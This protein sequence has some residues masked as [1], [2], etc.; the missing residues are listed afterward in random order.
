VRAAAREA[1]VRQL[2]LC[3]QLEDAIAAADPQRFADCAAAIEEAQLGRSSFD[4]ECFTA[5]VAALHDER[6][7]AAAGTWRLLLVVDLDHEKLSPD[8]R[9]RMLDALVQ[10]YPRFADASAC[11]HV[12][13]L[14][15]NRFAGSEGLQ[16]LASLRAIADD[17][18]RSYIA[19]GL[20]DTVRSADD[21]AVRGSAMA[22]L[23]EMHADP[24]E[25]VRYEVA[26]ALRR[27]LRRGHDGADLIA[28]LTRLREDPLPSVRAAA[29]TSHP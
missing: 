23:L 1:V 24:A 22:R 11:F 13:E 18:R 5:L 3:R 15:G 4:E 6:F 27:L 10:A 28:A 16:A 7:Q 21:D 8:Q 2:D 26:L 19:H 29:N 12:T 25:R 14:I 9:T 17:V 20:G